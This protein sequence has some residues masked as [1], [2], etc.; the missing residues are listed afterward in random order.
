MTDQELLNSYDRATT[1]CK[2]I[3]A[4]MYREGTS[5]PE[6]VAR[7]Q[8]LGK[9]PLQSLNWTFGTSRPELIPEATVRAYAVRH[10]IRTGAEGKQEREP[11]P[12]EVSAYC[13][14][15][16]YLETEYGE[17]C[18]YITIEGKRRGCPAGVGCTKRKRN[19]RRAN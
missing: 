16:I 12:G 5:L 13:K 17:S 19:G 6:I 11:K 8:R 1:K 9:Q 3:V 7:L 10:K 2:A 18:G 4:A 14:G 15:C